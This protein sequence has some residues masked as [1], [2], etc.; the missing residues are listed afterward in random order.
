M[1]RKLDEERESVADELRRVR[2]AARDDARREAR[3]EPPRPAAPVGPAPARPASPSGAA[4]TPGGPDPAPRPAPS[5]RE[6]NESW[7][8]EPGG[9]RGGPGRLLERL[10]A[11]RLQA[12]RDWNAAQVRLDNEILSWVEARFAATHARYDALAG[13]LGRRLDEADERHRILERELLAHVRDLVTRIDLAMAD[14][15]RGRASHAQALL[16]L[17]ERIARLESELARRA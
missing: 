5:A 1:P 16:D 4:A 10:L 14:A 9:R 7:G 12:Q 6:V 3:D 11:P 15:S 17:R 2:E 13:Q 8:A